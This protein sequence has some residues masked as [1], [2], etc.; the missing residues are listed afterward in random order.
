MT[1]RGQGVKGQLGHHVDDKVYCRRI[2]TQFNRGEGHHR[3]ARRIFHGQRVEL[4]QRDGECQSDQ[5][6]ALG[7]VPRLVVLGNT[8][9]MEAGLNYL[10]IQGVTIQ[11]QGIIRPSPWDINT[12]IYWAGTPSPRQGPSHADSSASLRGPYAPYALERCLP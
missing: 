10:R 3:L 12:S 7:L 5:L 1:A 4:R 2:L 8:P 6:G 9:Y 11:R